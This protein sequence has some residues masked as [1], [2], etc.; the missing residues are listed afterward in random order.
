MLSGCFLQMESDGL[1][2]QRLLVVNVA[3]ISIV[4]AS[5]IMI[6]GVEMKSNAAFAVKDNTK[7]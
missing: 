1:A 7:Q 6:K 3:S 2:I 5:V 4:L